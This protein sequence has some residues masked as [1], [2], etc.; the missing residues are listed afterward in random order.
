M[1]GKSAPRLAA[2]RSSSG[3]SVV[4]LAERQEAAEELLRHLDPREDV[5]VLLGV[6]KRDGEAQREVRDVRE[7]PAE[8]DHE[9]GQSR[10]H[11]ALE[12]V[13]ELLALLV[14]RLGDGQ[15]PDAALLELGAHR[16][17]RGAHALALLEHALRDRLDLRG[18]AHAVG[19]LGLAP[20]LARVLEVRDA[21]HEELVQV[22]LPDRAELDALEQRDALVLGQLQDA[23][24]E[25]EPRELAV[26]VEAGSSRSGRGA[27]SRRLARRRARIALRAWLSSSNA[28]AP[29]GQFAAAGGCRRAVNAGQA[30]VYAA[31][32]IGAGARDRVE[33]CRRRG[34]AGASDLRRSRRRAGRMRRPSCARGRAAAPLRRE[35]SRRYGEAASWAMPAATLSGSGSDQ[36]AGVAARGSGVRGPPASTATTGRPLACASAITWP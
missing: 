35:C 26:E 9:R 6:A 24:V 27:A 4:P 31:R 5:G 19:A 20:R 2:I 11:L 18:D 33:P 29:D 21:H 28:T 15:D 8:A 7:R 17:E 14:G 23:V 25:L 12:E 10:E 34:S 3:T 13:R 36:P 22:R 32:R 1:P 16:L 30:P